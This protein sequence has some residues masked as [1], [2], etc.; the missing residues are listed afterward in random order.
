M[1]EVADVNIALYPL[2]HLQ[3]QMWAPPPPCKY[4]LVTIPMYLQE[5]SKELF[6]FQFD[7]F[8]SPS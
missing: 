2:R 1:Q 3:R 8:Y 4:L 7:K 5:V 6:G